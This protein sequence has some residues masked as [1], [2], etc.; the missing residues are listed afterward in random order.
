MTNVAQAP[1]PAVVAAAAP[2]V[3]KLPL[4][5]KIRSVRRGPVAL[6]VD[7]VVVDADGTSVKSDSVTMHPKASVAAACAMLQNHITVLAVSMHKRGVAVI[8]PVPEGQQEDDTK[9][10]GAEFVGSVVT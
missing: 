1:V 9:L 6:A 7:A 8:P 3:Y 4:T 2:T 5:M 10:T